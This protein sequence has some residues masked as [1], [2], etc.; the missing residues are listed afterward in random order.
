MLG[1]VDDLLGAGDCIADLPSCPLDPLAAEGGDVF[2]SRGSPSEP[3][4]AAV[5]CLGKTSGSGVNTV[6]GVGGPGQLRRQGTYA[7]NGFTELD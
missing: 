4:S 3:R 6:V 1:N 7:T 2:N 5:F